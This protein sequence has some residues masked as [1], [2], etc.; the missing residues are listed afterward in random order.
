M[1]WTQ[2]MDD[3]LFT[4]L[5]TVADSDG[6]SINAAIN[7]AVR[8]YIAS[9]DTPTLAQRFA[10]LEKVAFK[11]VFEFVIVEDRRFSDTFFYRFAGGYDILRFV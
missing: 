10:Q 4:Q 2:R 9:K 7:Q 5:K 3:D 6:M 1:K 11:L 8:V